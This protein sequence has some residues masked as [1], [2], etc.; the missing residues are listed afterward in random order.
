MKYLSWDIG[1]INLSYCL[2]EVENEKMEILNWENINISLDTNNQNET[3]C[4]I[5]KNK[6]V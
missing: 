6:K 3:C 5:M 1:I 4:A 2:L